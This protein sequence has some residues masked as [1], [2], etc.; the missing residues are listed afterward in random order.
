[1]MDERRF[2][3][4]V[5][6]VT[7]AGAEGGLGREYARLLARRGASVVIN[8]IGADPAG[9]GAEASVAE[10]AARELR[11]EGFVAI[12]DTNSVATEDGAAAIVQTAIDQFG[13][14][15]ILVNNAGVAIF[16]Q[17]DEISSADIEKT[18]AVHLMGHIWMCRAAWPHFK[19][20]EYG[21]VVN[22]CSDALMGLR[23]LSIYG[24][25]KGGIL[26][27]TWGLAVDG[28]P[29]GIKVN[30]VGPGAGTRA[31]THWFGESDWQRHYVEQLHPSLVAPAVAALAHEDCPATAQF[32]RAAGA[33][34][35]VRHLMETVGHTAPEAQTIESIYEHWDEIVARNGE[36]EIGIAAKSL[37]EIIGRSSD[38]VPNPYTAE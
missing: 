6:I 1:M 24:A 33:R 10:D 8:D 19:A 18:V 35:A 20:A 22:I 11:N 25:V 23:K 38:H 13:K 9:R 36:T 30:V 15:D 37:E 32:V 4:R 12:A 26:S 34:V 2:D 5:A 28:A 14:L 3:G 17:F 31:V 7:G 16:A 27:L 29:H 21:R